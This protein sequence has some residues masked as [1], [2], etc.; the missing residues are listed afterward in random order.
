MQSGVRHSVH[1]ERTPN[2]PRRIV[3]YADEN[4]MDLI[5]MGTRGQNTAEMINRGSRSHGVIENAHCPIP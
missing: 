2:I 3:R 4:S 1:Y 5:A